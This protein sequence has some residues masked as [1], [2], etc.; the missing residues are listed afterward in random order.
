MIEPLRIGSLRVTPVSEVAEKAARR[1]VSMR[2][3][4]RY[5]VT[6]CHLG[7]VE[8]EPADQALDTEIV[9]TYD[10]DTLEQKGALPWIRLSRQIEEDLREHRRLAR[11]G[12]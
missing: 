7:T 2:K 10:P 9:G 8:I 12:E 4:S 3:P 5:A 6:C 1:L 11:G